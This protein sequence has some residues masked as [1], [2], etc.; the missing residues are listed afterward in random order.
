LQC[1]VARG[2]FGPLRRFTAHPTTT[3]SFTRGVVW[4]LAAEGPYPILVIGGEQGSAKHAG[5]GGS[6]T[7]PS[8]A[9]CSSR[10]T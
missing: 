2:D 10:L 3:P 9:I 4:G 1:R 8:T 6:D 5:A 7:D